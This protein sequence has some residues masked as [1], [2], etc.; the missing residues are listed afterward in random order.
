MNQVRIWGN[1]FG[2]DAAASRLRSFLHHALG[3]GM[4]CSL[5][6]TAVATRAPHAGEHEVPL[7]DGVRDRSVPTRLPQTEVGV[8]SRAA[9]EAIAATAPVVVFAPQAEA[10]DWLQLAGLEWPHAAAVFV[11]REPNTPA[12][13]LERVRAEARW[14]GADDPPHALD[15]RELAPWLALPFVAGEGA[16]VHVGSAD[17]ADGTDLAIDAWANSGPNGARLRLVLPDADD[18][19]VAAIRARLADRAAATVE[20][21]RGPFEAAHVRDA[22][23]IVLPWR[24][25]R[26]ARVL[27][28]ALASGRAVCVSRFPGTAGLV[29]RHGTC[30]PIG[31]CLVAAEAGRAERFEP[32]GRAVAAVLRQAAAD[33][34][35]A[36]ATGR[37]GRQHVQ[38]HFVR[39]VPSAPP[40][41]VAAPRQSRPAVVLEAPFFE[42]S[43]S[44]ELSIE[45]ARALLRAGNVDLRLVPTLPMVTDLPALRRRAPELVPLLTRAPGRPDLW[46]SSGWPIR[47]ARPDCGT[48]ALRVDWEFGA[49]PVEVTPHVT[50]EADLV[51]VHSEHVQ[52]TVL[53]AGRPL[54]TVR[55]V[56]HGVDPAMHDAA[57][58]A[59]EIVAWK[60]ARPAVLFCGGLVWRKGFDVFLGAV[61]AARRN[62]PDFC[63][64]VKT[65]GRDQ[66]YGRF[67][68]DQLLRRYQD[69]PGTP[70]LRVVDGDL[71][72]DQLASLYTACDVL[73][74]PYRGEGFCLPVLEARACGLPVLATGGGATDALMVG[75]GAIK[76]PS[77]RRAVELPAPHVAEPWLLEPSAADTGRLLTEAL[78]EIADRRAAARGCAAAVRAAF[79]WSAA[80]E[81][82]EREAF[83]AMLGRRTPAKRA[84]TERTVVLPLTA[85]GARRAEPVPARV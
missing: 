30:L 68:L 1:P 73:V 14:A 16:I 55:I 81:A 48:W 13:L 23:A 20:I 58:P 59:A 9:A 83:A 47:A 4:R 69:T 53:A 39:G 49:L 75:P 45:T 78:R 64:V 27:V 80:A 35:A 46:L 31:G 72:R 32:D 57:P 74:H 67:N 10:S 62:A 18:A 3:C 24:A 66:H 40:G 79:P 77:V 28:Q 26:S 70:P 8:L 22:T 38:E 34:T 85:A 29:G 12:D 52:R 43:S 2:E 60:G 5:S 42:T 56:P 44:A 71:S 76:I 82:I 33:P 25:V 21:V 7:T 84:A 37:R 11:A 19:V 51:I 17:P 63:V 61:L 50:Q 41:P 36:V 15:E 6:L 65:V 54:T